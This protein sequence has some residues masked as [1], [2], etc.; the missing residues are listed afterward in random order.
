[1]EEFSRANLERT[2]GTGAV[3]LGGNRSNRKGFCGIEAQSIVVIFSARVDATFA[4]SVVLATFNLSRFIRA[5]ERQAE[6]WY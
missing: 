2:S 1:M 6:E 4:G 5:Q 3:S